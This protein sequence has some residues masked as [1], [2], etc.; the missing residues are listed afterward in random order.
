MSKDNNSIFENELRPPIQAA[1]ILILGLVFMVVSKLISWT[2]IIEVPVRFPWMTAGAFLLFFAIVNC[3][4]FLASKEPKKY[5]RDSI[6]SYMGLVIGSGCLA[7]LFSQIPISKA[8]SYQWIFF[9]L[10]FG[11]LLFL[12]MMGFFR[13]IVEVAQREDKRFVDK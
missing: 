3:V 9:V 10:S 7:W 12:S 6:Y 5:F 4:F 1:G 8:A 2:G 13:K 11:Y